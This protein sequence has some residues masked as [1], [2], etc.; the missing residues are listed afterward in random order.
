[1][2]EIRKKIAAAGKDDDEKKKDPSEKPEKPEKP[3][4]AEKSEKPKKPA[5]KAG[6]IRAREGSSAGGAAQPAKDDDNL[7]QH[8]IP[9]ILPILP[10]RNMV[11]YP[12]VMV[13]ILV[14]RG[15]SVRLIDD[16]LLK[17][18]VIGLVAQRDAEKEDP[19][20]EDLFRVGTAGVILKMLKF[21]DGSLRVLIQGMK[22][23]KVKEFTE[24]EP[25][26]KAK[27]DL[28]EDDVAALLRHGA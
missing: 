7:E 2:S 19:S 1:M 3:E 27:V 4:K 25:Y 18:K 15:K 21:P 24:S 13:P 16:V 20:P 26:F 9:E 10:V 11:L 5:E 8:E 14:G 12:W 28:L 17:S 23:F 6:T 22:R